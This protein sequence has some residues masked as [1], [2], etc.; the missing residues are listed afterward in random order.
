[1]KVLDVSWQVKTLDLRHIRRSEYIKTFSDV[2]F[3]R[4]AILIRDF[5]G[6]L[7]QDGKTVIIYKIT[8]GSFGEV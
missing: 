1:M 5:E 4:H 6:N 3:S 8:E 2:P 7:L